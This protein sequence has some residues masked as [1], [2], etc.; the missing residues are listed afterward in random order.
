M[1]SMAIVIIN[2]FFFIRRILAMLSNKVL[3]IRHR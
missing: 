1:A 2:N 3:I